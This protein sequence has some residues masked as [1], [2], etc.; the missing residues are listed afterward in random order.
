M[1]FS[2]GVWPYGRSCRCDQGYRSSCCSEP[3]R[4][5]LLHGLR[6][7]SH[8][9]LGL[10]VA[11]TCASPLILRL[12]VAELRSWYLFLRLAAWNT[13]RRVRSSSHSLR[14]FTFEQTWDRTATNCSGQRMAPRLAA[15]GAGWSSLNAQ[16][17]C[18]RLFS[19]VPHNFS[20]A[21]FA[22]SL[23]FGLHTLCAARTPASCAR[24]DAL[25]RLNGR[26]RSLWRVRLS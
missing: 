10:V 25:V 16:C 1:S 9:R 21:V 4:P 6:R 8:V 22:R 7:L 19:H 12:E 5:R 13:H 14:S 2:V 3:E 17:D 23:V 11:G 20:E 18:L 15:R 26:F 24:S